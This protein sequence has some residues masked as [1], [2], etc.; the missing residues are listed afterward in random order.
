MTFTLCLQLP[1]HIKF[2]RPIEIYA[3]FNPQMIFLQSIFGYLVLRLVQ[4]VRR[5]GEIHYSGAFAPEHA[6]QQVPERYG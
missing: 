6:D 2:K 5:L 3:N 4:L 1:N